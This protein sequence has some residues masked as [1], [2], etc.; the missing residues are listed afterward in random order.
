MS[1]ALGIIHVHV[2]RFVPLCC[3]LHFMAFKSHAYT[4]THGLVHWDT[5]PHHMTLDLPLRMLQRVLWLFYEHF[6]LRNCQSLVVWSLNSPMHYEIRHLHIGHI[7]CS[8]NLFT[9][10]CLSI[11]IAL[12]TAHDL[13]PCALPAVL[14]HC[15]MYLHYTV[16]VIVLYRSILYLFVH[17]M[18]RVPYSIRQYGIALHND[19]KVT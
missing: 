13:L 2:Y 15:F 11:V 6:I 19:A 1:C 14:V 7:Q 8:F 16:Y 12:C 9:N 17:Y 10:E 18:S 5:V 4:C 3:T